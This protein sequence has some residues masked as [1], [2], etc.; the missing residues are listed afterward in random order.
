VLSGTA[1][2]APTSV[3]DAKVLVITLGVA[4]VQCRSTFASVRNPVSLV[5]RVFCVVIHG[6]LPQTTESAVIILL[7]LGLWQRDIASF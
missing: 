2:E 3:S 5:Q 6:V 4:Q 7:R 1:A